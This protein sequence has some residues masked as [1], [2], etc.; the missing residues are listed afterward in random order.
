MDENND[1]LNQE[2]PEVNKPVPLDQL[3]NKKQKKKMSRKE[4]RVTDFP[5][6]PVKGRTFYSWAKFFFVLTCLGTGIVGAMIILPF[7]IT[8]FGIFSVIAWL[9]LIVAGTIFT[10]GMIWLSDDTKS[11][12]GEWQKLNEKT[13]DASNNIYSFVEKSIPAILISGGVVILISWLFIILGLNKD[14]DRKKKFK[15]MMIALIVITVIY[16]I[17]LAINLIRLRE[18]ANMPVSSSSSSSFNQQ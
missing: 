15:G 6:D 5:G 17:F 7:F 10:L 11:F 8:L 16:V 2:T 12:F 3:P 14:P 9:V 4:R 18:Y 1:A 13:L